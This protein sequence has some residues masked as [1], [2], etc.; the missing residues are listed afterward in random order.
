MYCEGNAAEPVHTMHSQGRLLAIG[1]VHGQLD[2][3]QSLLDLIQFTVDDRLVLLGDFVD[4][5]TDSAGVLDLVAGLLDSGNVVAL[6]GNHDDVM[7]NA[8]Q[9]REYFSTWMH[10]MGRS[11]IDSYPRDGETDLYELVRRR[12][13]PVLERLIL[14][15]E[16]PEAIFVHAT[17]DHDLPMKEQPDE[18][19]LWQKM[20]PD[21]VRPHISGK[22]IICGHTR[23]RDGLPRN[24]GWVVCIDT[25]AKGGGWLT[26]LDVNARWCWQA[27]DDGATREFPL[28]SSPQD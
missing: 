26:C 8:L 13:L 3:L 20:T 14:W 18:I 17:V 24:W 12:H 7:L 25:D 5:G 2:A 22:P 23:Q 10:G 1:D 11:T 16:E 15:H 6:R 21:L 9:S 19:L 4:A 28:G 27:R